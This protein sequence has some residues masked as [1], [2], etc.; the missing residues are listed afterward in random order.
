MQLYDCDSS[1]GLDNSGAM[2]FEPDIEVQVG[3]FNTSNSR[4]WTK[5]R[6][7]FPNQILAEWET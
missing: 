3:V 2:K 7:N 1:T 5:L 6:N 4:L